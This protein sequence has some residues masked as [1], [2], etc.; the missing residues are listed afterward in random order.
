MDPVIALIA[1]VVGYLLGAISFAR[2]VAHAVDPTADVTKI[3]TVLGEGVTFTSDSVSA[4]AVR[5]KVGRRYGILTAI[6]DMVKVA[7]PTLV[8]RL[9]FPDQPYYLIVAAAGLIGHDWP[10]YHR[11]LGGRGETA[12][13]GAL[14]VIDP[15]GVV[16]TLI[17]GMVLGFIL[18][19]ILVLRWAGM[20]LLIPWFWVTTGDPALVA[21]MVFADA[22]YLLAMRPELGQYFAMR[23]EHVDPT[24]EEIADEFGMGS[25]LG[26]AIDRY[27]LPGLISR[28]RSSAS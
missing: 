7:L 25:R 19:N 4:T 2:L 27:G 14:L 21:Y 20:V 5:M 11:F 28:L 8:F 18:G 22:V 10:V 23:H 13:Y 26:R 16:V 17:L 12:I 9:A 6:L 1:A 3:E 15:I 24:N